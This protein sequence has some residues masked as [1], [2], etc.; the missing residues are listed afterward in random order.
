MTEHFSLVASCEMNK[1]KACIQV[2]TYIK[3]ITGRLQVGN[4][5]GEEKALETG[6]VNP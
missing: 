3:T 4:I 5:M 2:L 6:K 1:R